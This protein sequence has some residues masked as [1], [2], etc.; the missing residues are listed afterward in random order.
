[1][2]VYLGLQRTREVELTGLMSGGGSRKMRQADTDSSPL[3]MS[4]EA[5]LWADEVRRQEEV[6]GRG[7]GTEG[8]TVPHSVQVQHQRSRALPFSHVIV[9]TAPGMHNLGTPAFTCTLIVNNFNDVYLL[10]S[11]DFLPY[12]T[13]FLP[14]TYDLLALVEMMTFLELV[15]FSCQEDE[16]PPSSEFQ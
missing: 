4:W 16:L 9:F 6:T 11:L 8:T 7:R 10:S 5:I 1:M 14:I 2:R 3:S 15:S 13:L 12:H